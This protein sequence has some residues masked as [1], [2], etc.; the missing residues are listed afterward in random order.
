MSFRGV[1]AITSPASATPVVGDTI[2]TRPR[3]GFSVDNATSNRFSSPHYLLP[4]P[5]VGASIVHPAVPYKY[6]SNNPS[7]LNSSADKTAPYLHSHVKVRRTSP[8]V[9]L[10][11]RRH[12]A[13]SV[14]TEPTTDHPSD[15]AGGWSSWVVNL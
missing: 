7:G 15:S 6:G 3:G 13:G 1:T 10:V 5:I 2:V 14:G 4:F 8:S 12:C 9:S 11:S